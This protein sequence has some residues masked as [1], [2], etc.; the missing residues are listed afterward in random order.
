[1]SRSRPDVVSEFDI[2]ARYFERPPRTALIGVGDDCALVK[3]PDGLA[4]AVT[5]DMLLEGVHFFA[6]VSPLALGHKALA[7]NLSDLAAM[8]AEPRWATLA[9]AL[10]AAD[11]GWLEQFSSGFF[12]LAE[13][14][15]LELVG[16][17]TTRGPL[18]ICI[19]ALGLSPPGLALRR[20]GACPAD[21]VWLSGST[22]EAAL[23][24]AALRGEIDLA[25]ADR[26]SCMRRLDW[27]EPRVEL[28][29]ALR[30]IANSAIDV[31]DGLLQDLGH[32]C[33]RSKVA[34]EILLDSLPVT[35]AV[36]AAGAIGV[37]A[38]LAGGDDYELCFTAPAARREAIDAIG[39]RLGISL[40]R[41]GRIVS[42]PPAVSVLDAQ[43][44]PLAP[45]R[46]GF[47]HFG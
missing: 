21:D 20:D 30:S 11:E 24:V 27:P 35:P 13:R 34:A 22:G 4:L 12:A 16:G 29:C 33:E 40:A 38:M 5:S 9:L 2:I 25:P 42:G 46:R 23:A 45:A 1:M 37:Q 6:G 44:R 8:G 47:D 7:V 14:Y 19:T 18:T 41:I 32:I 26:G 15:R 17:D 31:S 36:G 28:G 3:P 10:P 39:A 43:G